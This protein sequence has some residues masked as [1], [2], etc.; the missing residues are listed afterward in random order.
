MQ[1]EVEPITLNL[2]SP[3]RI[4]HGTSVARHNVLVRISD[5]EQEGLGEA[6]PALETRRLA[7]GET[8]ELE[9]ARGFGCG[10]PHEPHRLRNHIGIA[11]G[12]Q[13]EAVVH[14]GDGADDLVA[15]VGGQKLNNPVVN[16]PIHMAPSAYHSGRSPELCRGPVLICDC[17]V[18]IDFTVPASFLTVG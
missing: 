18:Y 14:R 3:F 15:E 11:S 10:L 9:L 16:S 4:A 12:D 2:A 7:I 6:A 17:P 13:L 8:V 5:G 1:L